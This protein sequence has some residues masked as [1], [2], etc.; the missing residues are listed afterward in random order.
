[1]C[2]LRKEQKLFLQG[3]D[4]IGASSIFLLNHDIFFLYILVVNV[5]MEILIL[6]GID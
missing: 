3:E 1:M 6:H 5:C 2:K 4:D